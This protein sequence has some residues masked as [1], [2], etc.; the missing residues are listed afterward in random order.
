MAMC[1]QNAPAVQIGRTEVRVQNE[2]DA[3]K[4]QTDHHAL[5]TQ[6]VQIALKDLLDRKTPTDRQDHLV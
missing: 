5:K 2:R 1:D 4:D 3:K 6:T